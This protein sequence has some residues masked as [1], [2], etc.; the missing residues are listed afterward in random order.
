MQIKEI[1]WQIIEQIWIHRLWP[2]RAS[3]IEPYSAMKFMDARYEMSFAQQPQVF[4]GG[5]INNTLVAV[6][7]LHLAETY[8]A[9]SRGLNHVKLVLVLALS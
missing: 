4:L 5:Y 1:D 2:N 9:R 3:I 8:M 7:S 6:N